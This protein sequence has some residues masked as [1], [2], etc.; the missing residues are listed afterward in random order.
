DEA[1]SILQQ[2]EIAALSFTVTPQ[3]FSYFHALQEY[4]TLS[5]KRSSRPV[6]SYV[7]ASLGH[8]GKKGDVLVDDAQH[9]QK[10]YGIC[11]GCGGLSPSNLTLEEIKP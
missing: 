7:L 10:I 5:A 11:D 3:I 2:R 1:L 6:G 9:P 8:L 4:K